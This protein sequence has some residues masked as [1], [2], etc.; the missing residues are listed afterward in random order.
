MEIEHTEIQKI[1][2]EVDISNTLQ[3]IVEEY[4]VCFTQHLV[5]ISI[6]IFNDLEK[7]LISQCKIVFFTYSS[8]KSLL[9]KWILDEIYHLFN[10][11]R[12]A[13]EVKLIREQ[14]QRR[15]V[16]DIF[17][18]FAHEHQIIDNQYM[19][20]GQFLEISLRLLPGYTAITGEDIFYVH[21]TTH[22][23]KDLNNIPSLDVDSLFFKQLKLKMCFDTINK[24]NM[25]ARVKDLILAFI[26][27]DEIQ[28]KLTDLFIDVRLVSE[29]NI[30]SLKITSLEGF[31]LLFRFFEWLSIDLKNN[32]Y[33]SMNKVLAS[34]ERDRAILVDRAKGLTLEEVGVKNGDITRERARQI[35]NKYSRKLI[36]Y[37]SR[38]R[39]QFI[40]RAFSENKGYIT[41]ND[42]DSVYKDL[43]IIV[44]YMFK[45]E[46]LR[47]LVWVSELDGFMIDS[48]FWLDHLREK[49][50]NFPP[51][52]FDEDIDN[53][54][55]SFLQD[56]PINSGAIKQI[57]LGSI[58]RTGNVYS[59]NKLSKKDMYFT[60]LD[61][62]YPDGIKLYDDFEMFRFR[63]HI[64]SL[65]GNVKLSDN[66]R[67]ICARISDF[68][69]LCDTGKYILPKYIKID[70]E[71]LTR[72]HS[73]IIGNDRTTIAFYEIFERFKDELFERM[74]I[75]NWH[76][77][78]GILKFKYKDEFEFSKD[79]ITKNSEKEKSIKTQI[80]EFI[81]VS[82]KTISAEE[83]KSEFLGIASYTLSMAISNNPNIL[84]W[85]FGK[86][87]HSS[88]LLLV[89]KVINRLK[90]TLD[91]I[92]R[93]QSTISMRSF[94]PEIYDKERDFMRS[95]EIN[96]HMALFSIFAYLFPDE[97]EFSRP[98]IARKGIDNINL[99]GI[100]REYLSKFDEIGASDLKTFL[101][102]KQIRIT[103][104]SELLE[105]ISD[106][107]IRVDDDLLLRLNKLTLTN[108]IY[109]LIEES[110]LKA[111]G[112]KGYLSIKSIETFFFFPEIGLRWTPYLLVSL[113]KRFGKKITVFKEIV[114][115]RYLTEV[116]VCNTLNI[117]D[118]ND[119]IHY[120]LSFEDGS[121]RFN[122]TKQIN[123]FL[124]EQ[125]LTN[126]GIPKIF[127]DS[128]V[129]TEKDHTIVIS[130]RKLST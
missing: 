84:I 110:L 54:S 85:G 93:S 103:N 82:K 41:I 89:D 51:M 4:H 42:L 67:A 101:E 125:G 130:Q 9:V 126:N 105:N 17:P 23:S 18:P 73:F 55:S 50:L 46:I 36:I 75:S 14:C 58:K 112:L 128:G 29:I 81:K 7:H 37:C 12:D 32:L 113:V 20:Y 10:E 53:F 15:F 19:S 31:E 118:Y 86:Y 104:F 25:S 107:F 61:K 122:N 63:D 109:Q 92:L 27:K 8:K 40:L 87:I 119:L 99:D 77:L 80:E 22:N 95:N 47:S 102:D 69:I 83:I 24:N 91:N 88:K 79:V 114:D 52:V 5:P 66:N 30:E 78:Q 33:K 64:R 100:I 59:R 35:E 72:I 43:S 115:Y 129:I 111:I 98:F 57:I 76:Y 94:F 13:L 120:A 117:Q 97:Y 45:N 56:S 62:C 6:D 124:A 116:F 65:F 34:S 48:K 49:I 16:D 1:I 28:P 70:E 21:E 108:D 39:P 38:Y 96:N 90:L 71:L 60:V 106:E 2:H 3:N 123:E 121:T 74:N 68:S 44:S 11:K 26:H 127:L